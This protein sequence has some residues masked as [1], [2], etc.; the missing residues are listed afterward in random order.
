MHE[1][2][3]ALTQLKNGRSMDSNGIAAEMV[4]E[5]GRA[6]RAVLLDLF[7][8]VV[9]PQSA[10]PATRKHTTIAVLHKSGDTRLPQNY[11]PIA[12]VPLLYKLFSKLLYNRLEPTL[13]KQQ[14]ADQA[15]FR[16]KFGT[17]DH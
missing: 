1:L 7:N 8:N 15:G 4:K 11:R 5:G 2:D 12:I 14:C 3:T 10:P 13:D 9:Q 16:K 6:L 17:E